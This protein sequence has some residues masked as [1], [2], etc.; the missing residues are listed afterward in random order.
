MADKFELCIDGCSCFGVIWSNESDET[1]HI[2]INV[3]EFCLAMCNAVEQF[4]NTDA[5]ILDFS[6]SHTVI[7]N[8]RKECEKIEKLNSYQK[9][10]GV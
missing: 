1:R 3:E 8:V 6:D 10:E 9:L 2:R 7:I 5:D 4:Y